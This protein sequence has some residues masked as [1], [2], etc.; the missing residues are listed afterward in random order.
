M[1]LVF[2]NVK[3]GYLIQHISILVHKLYGQFLV[4]EYL[5]VS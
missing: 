2:L 3:V 1:V 5:T 4:N